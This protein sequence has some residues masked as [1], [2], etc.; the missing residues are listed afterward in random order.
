MLSRLG[1]ARGVMMAPPVTGGLPDTEGTSEE[2]EEED[3][4]P[5]PPPPVYDCVEVTMEGWVVV[6]ED[7]GA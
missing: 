4:L 2:E 1:A 5:P 7:D 6:V 3:P